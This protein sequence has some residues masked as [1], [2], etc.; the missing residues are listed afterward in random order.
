MCKLICVTNRKLCSGDFAERIER[1]ASSGADAVILRE[2]D[3]SENDYRSLAEKILPVCKKNNVPCI[4]HSF[5]E[6]VLQLKCDSIHLPLHILREL[7]E[8]KK[9][10]FR[11]LGS[12]V[13]SVSEAK[14]AQQL[15]CTYITA[16]HIFATDC[17]KGLAPRGTEFLKEVVKTVDIPVYAIGGIDENNVKSVLDI[18]PGAC[19][20]S[21]FMTCSDEK[22]FVK[23][24]KK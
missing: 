19:I 1:I 12:S 20:M 11:T 14:E 13:H 2:K 5:F 22:E 23:G 7:P 17:K 10:L 3:L 15:G 4:L 9:Q 16:G 24:L 21:G 6:T 8:E 18:C